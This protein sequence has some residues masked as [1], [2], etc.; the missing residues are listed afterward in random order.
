MQNVRDVLNQHYYQK[1]P[2]RIVFEVSAALL[3]LFGTGLAISNRDEIKHTVMRAFF[4]SVKKLPQVQDMMAKE[5]N[6]LK[7]KLVETMALGDAIP[8]YSVIPAQGVSHKE[9]LE[10]MT[11]IAHKEEHHISSGKISGALYSSDK[12]L[13]KLLC[14]VYTLFSSANAL[15]PTIFPSVRKFEAE[16]VRMT[17]SMMKGDAEACGAITSG[18][19]ESILMA[20]KAQRV[21]YKKANPEMIVPVTGH[22]AFDKAA[23]YFKIKLVHAP[24]GPDFKVD[25]SAVRKLINRNTILIVGSAPGF[26]H[27]MIDPI[28]ELAALAHE[29]GI[30]FHTDCCLGGFMLPWVREAGIKEVPPFDFSVKGVT[31]MSADTHKY[32]YATKGTSVV[33]FKTHELRRSMYFVAPNW[34]GGMYASPTIA[35]SRPGAL[36]ACCWA[37]LVSNGQDAYIK[38]SV[39]I[40][41]TAQEVKEGIRKIPQLTLVGDS[42]TSVVAFAANNKTLNIFKVA[43]AMTSKGWHLNNLQRPNCVHICITNHHVGKANVFIEDLDNSVR[44]VTENPDAFPNGSAGVYGMAASFPDR[45]TVAEIG[46]SYLDICLDVF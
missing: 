6:G 25:V 33:M 29:H 44:I 10:L 8:R 42:Y 24:L 21:F 41:N 40:W 19:T 30:G 3:G 27:G 45:A 7:K 32:G 34:P 22:A 16:I 9:I 38:K 39:A 23:S 31:S 20:V 11:D 1:E 36:I 14:Q 46:V 4:D 5:K 13:T 12:E 35:G 17:V 43:D 15:H 18:G 2:A 28:E 37:A 26:P